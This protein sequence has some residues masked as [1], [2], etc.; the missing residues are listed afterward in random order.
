MG[1]HRSNAGWRGT[2]ADVWEGGH[3]VPFVVRWPGV[4]EAGS[5]TTATVVHTDLYA[6]LADILGTAPGPDAAEDSVSMLPV[7]RGETAT[8]GVPVVH[9]SS[10]GMFAIRD[11]RWKLVL[12][13]GSGGR[14]TPR[15]EP[16][17]RPYPLFD[18]SR[19]PGEAR[20]VAAEHPEVVERLEATFERFRREG[21]SAQPPAR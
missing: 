13:N 4:V 12:G 15:G 21:R 3:R 17:A 6:T 19:D 14:Q 18:L 8:R 16:F 20:D 11:G 5:E 1:R 10:G 2:K 7:L 9:H